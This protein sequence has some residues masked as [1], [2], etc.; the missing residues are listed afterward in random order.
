MGMMRPV[1]WDPV[2]FENMMITHPKKDESE[3]KFYDRLAK[4]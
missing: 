2:E 4:E 3:W 1:D